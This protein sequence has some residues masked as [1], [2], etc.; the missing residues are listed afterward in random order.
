MVRIFAVVLLCAGFVVSCGKGKKNA[1]SETVP[2]GS[3]FYVFDFEKALAD[4]GEDTLALNDISETIEF[5][6]LDTSVVIN[7][8]NF[9][10]AEVDG[11]YVV[12][13]GFMR[14]AS[15][16]M[17]FNREGGF[18]RVL[19]RLGRGPGE[20]DWYTSW[21]VNRTLESLTVKGGSLVL[22]HSFDGTGDEHFIP[23]YFVG[24]V[25]RLNDGSYVGMGGVYGN[26][27]KDAPYLSFFDGGGEVVSEMTGHDVYVDPPEGAAVWPLESRGFNQSY[28]GDGLYREMFNDTICRVRAVGDAEPYIC[29]YRGK[30]SPKKE[31]SFNTE[32]KRGQ[33]FINDILESERYVVATYVYDNAVRTA[34]WDK[35]TSSMVAD[36]PKDAEGMW[37]TFGHI[38]YRTPAGGVVTAEILSMTGDTMYCALRSHD[39]HEFMPDVAEDGNPVVIVAKLK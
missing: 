12:S 37:R 26:R 7:D 27:D 2:A 14:N 28:T 24:S 16:I 38:R 36:V 22:N 19:V 4:K 31:D 35:T 15:P 20:V 23:P 33:V 34:V 17:L 6:R 3:E 25:M 30:L 1:A 18:E 11:G 8:M 29:M 10:F 32:K 39:A 5:L 13:S 9:L 21:N